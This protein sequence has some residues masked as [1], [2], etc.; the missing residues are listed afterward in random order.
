MSERVEID[1]LARTEKAVASLGNFIKSTISAYVS[2]RTLKAVI[3]D[4]FKAYTESESSIAK[5]RAALNAAGVESNKAAK[6]MSQFAQSL[7]LTTTYSDE[8]SMA[9]ASMLASIGRLSNDG[10]KKILPLVQDFAS[11]MGMD[12]ESAANLVGKAISGNT[13][14]LGRYGIKIKESKDQ[15]ERFSD[16]IKT[17]GT[18]FGGMAEQLANTNAGQLKI[19]K[20]NIDDIKESIGELIAMAAGGFFSEFNKGLKEIKVWKIDPKTITDTFTLETYIKVLS[21][22]IKTDTEANEKIKNTFAGKMFNTYK[23]NLKVIEQYNKK[24]QEYKDQL[25]AIN[26]EKEKSK[27]KE[28][29]FL[30]ET[31][32]EIQARADKLALTADAYNKMHEAMAGY[33]NDTVALKNAEAEHLDLL[34]KQLSYSSKG[35][36]W[37]MPDPKKVDT[38]KEALEDY[39]HQFESIGN[40]VADMA[41]TMAQAFASGDIEAGL[42][43]IATQLA[44]ML[45]TYAISAAAAAAVA[46]NWPLCAFW[47]GIAGLGVIGVGVAST[48][49]TT[50]ANVPEMAS[51]GIVTRPTLALIGEA[52]PEAV[53]PLGRGTGGGTV[54]NHYHIAGSIWQ[55]Q[56]L[57]RAVA[58][59]QGSW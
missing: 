52:G 54:I 33:I 2:V 5:Y 45:V 4:S 55:T 22:K 20:N 32:E 1:I 18:R 53:V 51:G 36:G 31:P 37:W 34:I 6:S 21:N 57:A 9:A 35:E 12:L 47:L 39:K 40:T 16:I 14:A 13:G 41:I 48:I 3:V 30:P 42:K 49:G 15:T 26:K 59:A 8:E 28:S 25:A 29:D 38:S 43:S 46:M 44:S 56:D 10:I 50:S 24:L 7:Q 11:A 23:E 17:L 19:F 58:S 27:K